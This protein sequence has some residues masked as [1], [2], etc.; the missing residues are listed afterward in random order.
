M[1]T[2]NPIKPDD[3]EDNSSIPRYERLKQ[4]MLEQI[5]TGTLKPGD[6]IA[7]EV[8]LCKLYRWSRPTISR[9]LNELELK[10]VLTRIQGSGTYVATPAE[11]TDK[12][13]DIMVCDAPLNP[14]SEYNGPIFHGI[15]DV[16]A[17]NRLDVVYYKQTRI[18]DPK[19]V[20][21]A[22][23]DGVLLYAPN[24]DDLPEILKLQ[25]SGK[26]VVAMAMHSRIK[27]I[28]SIS[29]ENYEGLKN[30]VR[31]LVSLGHRRVALVTHGLAS[32][33]VQERILGFQS[34]MHASGIELNPAWMLLSNHPIT[35][36]VLENWF[37]GLDPRPTAF[38]VCMS[39]AFPLLHLAWNRQLEVPKDLS[40]VVTDDS[41]LFRNC[42]PTISA[43][44]QPLYE[45]GRR[46]L[47]KLLDMIRGKNKGEAESLPM[48]L[49]LRD[50][51][52]SPGESGETKPVGSSPNIGYPN[53]KPED[54]NKLR[55][56]EAKRQLLRSGMFKQPEKGLSGKKDNV[57]SLR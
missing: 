30:V 7:T 52:A 6:R 48:E 14:E 46:G 27:T 39:Q 29:T 35:N 25:E 15:R 8:E 37:D 26:A 28:A 45:M 24:M 55:E 4:I 16:A 23:V 11:P 22:G 9:A 44:R 2:D 38:I 18:P 17:E 12:D 43:I 53:L 20:E 33:D 32:S 1:S 40:I 54:A 49:I 3:L 5:R 57:G 13:L 47:T 41:E 31:R 10:G 42:S 56:L 19:V 36:K 51:V 50:S 21:D 34:E